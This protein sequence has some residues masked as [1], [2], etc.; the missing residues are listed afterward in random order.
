MRLAIS[1]PQEL[2]GPH[3]DMDMALFFPGKRVGG[4]MKHVSTAELL[5]ASNQGEQSLKI[6]AYPIPVG[7]NPNPTLRYLVK[8]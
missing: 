3:T 4:L 7:A 2:Q 5:P 8:R 1:F 6:H